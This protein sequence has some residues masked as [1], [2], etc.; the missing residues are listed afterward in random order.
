MDPYG[1]I[2]KWDTLG[3]SRIWEDYE[4]IYAGRYS[5]L[6]RAY[7]EKYPYEDLLL[8]ITRFHV[9][10]RE[11]SRDIPTWVLKLSTAEQRRHR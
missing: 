7:F 3:T 5:E 9:E 4:R 10:R 6:R 8:G 11:L 2:S 1:R